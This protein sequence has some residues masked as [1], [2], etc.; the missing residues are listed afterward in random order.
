MEIEKAYFTLPEV[1]E[2][3]SIS[4]ADLVYLAENDK[5]RLS[6]RVFGVP[7]ELG[8]YEEPREGQHFRIPSERSWFNGL[9]DLHARDVFELFRC[10]EIHI[11]DFRMP[12]AEYATL[13]DEN[14]SVLVMIGD[15]LLRREERDRFEAET[16][17]SGVKAGA[18][19]TAFSASPDYQDVTCGEH[20]FRLGPIQAQVVRVLHDAAR[21]GEPW[22]SGKAILSAAGSKSLKMSD[23]FKSQKQWRSLIES[24]GRGNYRL[25]LD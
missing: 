16:G 6:V 12:G 1:L 5:L 21:R 18:Q 8:D 15:L 7:L 25:N 3:W 22:Q 9:L 14:R 4:E 19:R 11:S 17:F 10:S 23:V 13:Y 24:N 2:R 20:Q